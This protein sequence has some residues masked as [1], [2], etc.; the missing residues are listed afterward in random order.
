MAVTKIEWAT[1][2]MNDQAGCTK[3]SAACLNCY[4]LLLSIR[5]SA[6]GKHK[7]Y[8]GVTNDKMRNPKWT[9][10]VNCDLDVR[11]RN[12]AEIRNAIKPRRT[13]YGSM[14]DLFHE[15]LEIKGEELELLAAEVES[16]RSGCKTSQVVMFL[17][18]RPERLLAW[19][20][21][22]F[23]KGLPPQIWVGITVEDQKQA[24]DKVPTL[25]KVKAPVRYL[26][27]EPLLGDIQI[28]KKWAKKLE[29]V[30]V[31]GE[32]GHKA[33]ISD[34]GWIRSLRDQSVQEAIPFH[35]KQW[36]E[37]GDQGTRVGK[38]AAGRT[39]D[40]RTWDELPPVKTPSVLG[41]F[42]INKQRQE[43]RVAS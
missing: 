16:L 38:K 23:P 7:R 31:G 8:Q 32:S 35:F 29:W 20:K 24:D 9:G 19:Q 28:D 3:C 17:T 21:H 42:I 22:Y 6:M 41:G 18:K 40:G 12:F 43:V 26:S 37:Y 13:F 27:C 15:A 36:G 34:G 14:T 33:R 39:L 25:V 1:H 2:T 11:R 10:E 5:I 4:A 30:I